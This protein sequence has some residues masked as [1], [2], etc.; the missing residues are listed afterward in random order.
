MESEPDVAANDEYESGAS[1]P[2]LRRNIGH[3]AMSQR[4]TASSIGIL[5]LGV[6]FMIA[7]FGVRELAELRHGN[8]PTRSDKVWKCAAVLSSP[9]VQQ[10]KHDA[11]MTRAVK[12]FLTGAGQDISVPDSDCAWNA[13]FGILYALIVTRET[14]TVTDRSWH[15]GNPLVDSS[16]ACK[17]KRIKCDENQTITG[18]T[19]N[20]ANLTGTIPDE[21]AQGLARLTKLHL[22]SN[23]NLIGSIPSQFG[24]LELF[25]H[26]TRLTGTI[27]SHLGRLVLLK[28][29]LLD[30]TSLSGTMP[31]EICQLRAGNLH[32]LRAN[33][34]NGKVQC[35][36]PQCCTSCL[37]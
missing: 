14:L 8:S 13:P 31:S 37:P 21:L 5:I 3:S 22:Y 15:T 19:L 23:D 26:K 36:H 17:W 4:L 11:V 6:A 18:L 1:A 33:C 28:E 29:L 34:R 32:I 27:P 10:D 12:W 16:D 25:V 24:L 2:L 7:I 20:H 30:T 9:R 35:D